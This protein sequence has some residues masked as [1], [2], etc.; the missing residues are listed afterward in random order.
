MIAIDA[1]IELSNYVA[2]CGDIPE[3]AERELA[4]LRARAARADEL[5]REMNEAVCIIRALDGYG[6]ALP[7]EAHEL[8]AAYPAPEK[9]QP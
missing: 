1:A 4:A 2:D 5:E 6:V 9:T 8:L 7:D 3:D